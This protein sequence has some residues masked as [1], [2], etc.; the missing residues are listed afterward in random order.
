MAP[1]GDAIDTANMGAVMVWRNGKGH[2]FWPGGEIEP[3]ARRWQSGRA[4]V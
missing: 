4:L 2:G 3:N 1:K